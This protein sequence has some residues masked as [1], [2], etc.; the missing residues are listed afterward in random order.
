MHIV[1][2]FVIQAMIVMS[3]CELL[4]E[5]MSKLNM[6]SGSCLGKKADQVVVEPFLLWS[7]Q[8]YAVDAIG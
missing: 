2:L 3:T 8:S 4:G 6:K 5:L 7:F 1:V